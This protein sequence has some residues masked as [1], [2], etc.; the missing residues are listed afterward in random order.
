MAAVE[1]AVAGSTY[2][3]TPQIAHIT[4]EVIR[5]AVADLHVEQ[6]VE[7]IAGVQGTVLTVTWTQNPLSDVVVYRTTSP[8]GRRGAGAGGTWRRASWPAR[9][10]MSPTRSPAPPA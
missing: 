10:W 3:S 6:Q 8:V 9:A 1:V 4:P 5:E 7:T 2:T